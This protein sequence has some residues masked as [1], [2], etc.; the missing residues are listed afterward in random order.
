MIRTVSLI[1]IEVR[2]SAGAG[3]VS[4]SNPQNELTETDAKAQG[5]LRALDWSA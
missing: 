4:D 2:L 1:D 5:M 3:I